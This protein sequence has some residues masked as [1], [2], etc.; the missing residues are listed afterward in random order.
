M[1][2]FRKRKRFAMKTRLGPDSQCAFPFLSWSIL[3]RQRVRNHPYDL[4][5]SDRSSAQCFL[6]GNVKPRSQFWYVRKLTLSLAARV[7]WVMSSF[8]RLANKDLES[9]NPSISRGGESTL[10]DLITRWQKGC[11]NHPF[12]QHH[13]QPMFTGVL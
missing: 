3:N 6:A 8:N 11:I 4:S 1:R 10:T 7:C 9:G 5:Q 2:A 12:R 13:F